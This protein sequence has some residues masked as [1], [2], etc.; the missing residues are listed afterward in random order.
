MRCCAT[1][2]WSRWGMLG[3]LVFGASAARAD[4]PTYSIV[5]LGPF[6]GFVTGIN[7]YGQVAGWQGSSMG[8]RPFVWTPA[9]RNGIT[10]ALAFP[11]P[12]PGASSADAW[13]INS[14]GEL[15]G[16]SNNLAVLWNPT[17]PNGGTYGPPVELPQPQGFPLQLA[18]G[19][20]SSGQ[21][22]G[23][24]DGVPKA[25]LF[26]PTS[27]GGG[28]GSVTH[29]GTLPSVAISFAT[30]INDYGQVAGTSGRA[31]VWTPGTPNAASG[32]LTGLPVNSS[33]VQIAI[34]ASGSVAGAYT[35]S[36]GAQGSFLW[37]PDSPHG[38]TGS[39]VDLGALP[40][41]RYSLALSVNNANA[42]VGYVGSADVRG[43]LWTP[44]NGMVDLNTLL[45]PTITA[46]WSLTNAF[47]INNLGQ[48]AAAANFMGPGGQPVTHAVL[49]MPRVTAD[50]NGD[51]TV[52]FD[53][54]L[55]LAQ[56]YGISSGGTWQVDDF[57]GDGGVGFDDLLILAQH[58]GATLSDSQPGGLG[59]ASAVRVPEP[60]SILLSA[61]AAL[62]A[63]PRY[64]RAV[65][66]DRR[67]NR[68]VSNH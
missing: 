58:Y 30:S 26:T 16:R 38:S 2:G 50:A 59:A 62:L 36:G 43:F 1:C 67:R 47:A 49:L 54:L 12:L 31:F 23:R 11:D 19:V 65:Q 3:A 7:D 34:N 17:T 64:R 6:S 37:T 52:G 44:A 42:V 9:S 13:A 8:S 45:D 55:I 25:F 4:L 68:P 22:V 39:Y 21:I 46:G 41:S 27:P 33:Q 29:L 57:N 53:D 15:V 40:N 63:L 61:T 66:M 5:D 10:G 14:S 60:A 32:Q 20:N 56:H 18:L 35:G 48:I 51:G 28:T 24:T